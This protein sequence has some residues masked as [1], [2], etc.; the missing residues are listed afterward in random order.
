MDRS[1]IHKLYPCDD[2]WR[3]RFFLH[4]EIHQPLQ[5]VN[6]KLIHSVW[7]T[8]FLYVLSDFSRRSRSFIN[9]R[10]NLAALFFPF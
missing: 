5:E 7:F 6:L 8:G 2:L 10:T 4:G 3:L 1:K 9:G